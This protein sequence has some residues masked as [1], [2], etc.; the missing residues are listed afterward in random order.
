[1]SVVQFLKKVGAVTVPDDVIEQASRSGKKVQGTLNVSKLPNGTVL[2]TFAP[3]EHDGPGN[4]RPLL[5]KDTGQAESDL[6]GTFGLSPSE[7]QS[8]IAKVEQ[9]GE[10]DGSITIDEALASDLFL[11]REA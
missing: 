5:E 1:M 9:S 7:A 11:Y 6:V 3:T 2:M 10:A 8:W 4:S